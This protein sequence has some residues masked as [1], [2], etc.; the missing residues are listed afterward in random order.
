MPGVFV[1]TGPDD[2]WVFGMPWDPSADELAGYTPERCR[3]LIRAAAGVPD[4]D[5]EVLAAMPSSFV[6]QAAERS[7][8]GVVF[9]VGDAA[10]RMPPMG[11]RGMNTAIADAAGL[12]WKV[13]W[14]LRGWADP[15]LLDTY[16]AERGPVGRHNLQ[17]ASRQGPPGSPDG[18]AEDLGYVYRSAAIDPGEEPTGTAPA[19]RFPTVAAPGSRLPHAWL[20]GPTGELSTLD[21][22]GPGLTLL[23]GP[24]GGK[25]LRALESIAPE[26]AVPLAGYAIGR[27]LTSQDGVF[28]D[29][30]GLGGE[31]AIL[32]RPDGH[33][34][35]R[36]EDRTVTGHAVELRRAIA[37]CLGRPGESVAFAAETA[38]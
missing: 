1:P 34:A 3:T 15:A 38:A 33:I 9:L 24:R 10:H 8:E 16:E 23:T 31:G 25:W 14:V 4:L 29:R 7:R 6:A 35:W 2:R 28:D 20:A 27:E 32:V 26:L 13:A 21:L 22:I 17:R 11:G 37:C 12:A 36:R 30:F 19:P 18:L 5:V